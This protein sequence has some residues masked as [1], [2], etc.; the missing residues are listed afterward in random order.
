MS[1]GFFKSC[2][3]TLM[4]AMTL[5]VLSSPARGQAG[6]SQTCAQL[7]FKPGTKGH[8]DCVNQNSGV[9]KDGNV[10]TIHLPPFKS[11]SGWSIEQYSN[12]WDI[13]EKL[14]N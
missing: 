6:V 8:T 10:R 7:G 9:G 13:I 14:L 3:L 12:R 4:L 1:L 5:G 11:Y 2:A